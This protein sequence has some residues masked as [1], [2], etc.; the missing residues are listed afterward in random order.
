MI[1]HPIL[2]QEFE[3]IDWMK[4]RLVPGSGG[5]ED[6]LL[7]EIVVFIGTCASDETAAMFLCRSTSI[8]SK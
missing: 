5:G 8:S 2:T 4:E 6:D 3:M 1:P 7:L